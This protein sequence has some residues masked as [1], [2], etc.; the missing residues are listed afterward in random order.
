MRYCRVLLLF[1]FTGLLYAQVPVDRAWS[2][3]S[4]GA[5]DKSFQK[6]TQATQA[7]GLLPHDQKAREMAEKALGDERG[8]V[9]AAAAEAL[10]LIGYKESAPKL[11]KAVDDKEA[12][13]V[14]SAANALFALGDPAAYRVFYAVLTGQK[15]SG[16]GLMDSQMKMLKDPAALSK[17]GF[18]AG[19][20]FIPFG[21]I[22]YK[23][24][25]TVTK[26]DISPV[27]AAAAI[28]LVNDPDPK[29]GQALVASCKDDK[30]LVRAAA[31]GAIARRGDASL[32]SAIIPLLDDDNDVVRFTSAAAVVRLSAKG[33]TSGK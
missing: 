20:G 10:G 32:L 4:T 23:V 31:A 5:S 12:S 26:D 21:G 8:E 7:L 14:F 16:E 3:L 15:K 30:W 29:T 13:V 9:R 19:I 2:I 18:E 1:V 27:R 6:R 17:L 11:I 24:F 25:K 33:K 28:K 22:G